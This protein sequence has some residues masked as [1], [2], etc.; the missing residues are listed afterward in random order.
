MSALP[1]RL[2]TNDGGDPWIV[3]QKMFDILNDFLQPSSVLSPTAA[4][5]QLD[6]LF[7]LNRTDSDGE[8]KEEPE[9][10]LWELWS[11][12]IKVA[13]QI[14]WK[15]RAQDRLAELIKALR[16][17][18]SEIV[19]EIWSSKSRIWQDLPLLGP[20]LTET[21]RSELHTRCRRRPHAIDAGIG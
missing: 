6:R 17:L 14:P 19:V 3:E 2:I 18:P 1:L 11:V 16:D 5:K 7:P 10:F 21:M 4:A 15:S 9:S 13:Q 8:R 12:I 20:S